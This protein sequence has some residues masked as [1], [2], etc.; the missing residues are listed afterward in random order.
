MGNEQGNMIN[1]GYSFNS[2]NIENDININKS[3][4]DA[5]VTDKIKKEIFDKIKSYSGLNWWC[6][7]YELEYCDFTYHQECKIKKLV[8]ELIQITGHQINERLTNY[9]INKYR[10]WIYIFWNDQLMKYIE[11]FHI[12][13]KKYENMKIAIESN[14]N[15][16]ATYKEIIEIIHNS[17][18]AQ[19]A[20]DAKI[21][22]EKHCQEQSN[23]IES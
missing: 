11:H 12:L 1:H 23:K 4:T 13:D 2:I 5:D 18:E 9:K 3:L 19:L 10:T 8:D 14:Y 21:Q 22:F 17:K 6:T 15:I 16:N 20:E 7:E